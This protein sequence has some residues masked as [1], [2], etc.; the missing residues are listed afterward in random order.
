MDGSVR[1]E[2]PFRE[3]AERTRASVGPEGRTERYKKRPAE[4]DLSSKAIVGKP[5]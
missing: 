1:A 3:A 2:R 5:P 4:N